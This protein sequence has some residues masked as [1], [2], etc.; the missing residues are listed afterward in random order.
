ML[1]NEKRLVINSANGKISLAK[2]AMSCPKCNEYASENLQLRQE[3]F[4]LNGLLAQ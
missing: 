4:R 3:I 2:S 1:L